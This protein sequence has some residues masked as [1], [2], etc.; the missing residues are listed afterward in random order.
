MS[1]V[2]PKPPYPVNLQA[3]EPGKRWVAPTET[4]DAIV[5]SEVEPDATRQPIDA[6]SEDD[7]I[8]AGFDNMPV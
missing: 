4:D 8:E 5:L 7:L 3:V 6:P 1:P 2:P